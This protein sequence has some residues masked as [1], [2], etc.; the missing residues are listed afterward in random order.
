[1]CLTFPHFFIVRYVRSSAGVVSV[2]S[3]TDVFYF[4]FNFLAISGLQRT[5][6]LKAGRLPNG[7]IQH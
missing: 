4:F 2:I 3:D 7:E 6:M 1:M 5:F